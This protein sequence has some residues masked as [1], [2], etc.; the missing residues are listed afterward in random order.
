MSYEPSVPIIVKNIERLDDL[1]DGLLEG[2]YTPSMV[3][4]ANMIIS[5]QNRSLLQDLQLRQA[6]QR[7]VPGATNYRQTRQARLSEKG[8]GSSAPEE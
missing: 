1:Y 2:D 5:T 8:N 7:G 3:G 6:G 4:R